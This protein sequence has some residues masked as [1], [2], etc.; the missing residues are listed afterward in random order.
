MTES[1]SLF[2]A[3]TRPTNHY[4]TPTPIID[5]WQNQWG[6]SPLTSL[7]EEYRSSPPSP[8]PENLDDDEEQQPPPPNRGMPRLGGRYINR[9]PQPRGPQAGV[10]GFGRAIGGGLLSCLI[11]LSWAREAVF[12]TG[13]SLTTGDGDSDCW[14]SGGNNVRRIMSQSQD[15]SWQGMRLGPS[16][17]TLPRWPS[18]RCRN[19][20]SAIR[21][22]V[23]SRTAPRTTVDLAHWPMLFMA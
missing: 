12:R 4:R 14:V 21:A 2:P 22:F 20:R 13:V 7:P 6:D 8:I 10:A 11:L 19:T 9:F 1:D 18:T 17:A 5:P 16:I 3:L 15:P 23:S